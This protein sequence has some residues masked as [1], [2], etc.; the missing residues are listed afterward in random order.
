MIWLIVDDMN[1]FIELINFNIKN[2]FI[3]FKDVIVIIVFIRCCLL[4]VI[5]IINA[6]VLIWHVYIFFSI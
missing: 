3:C 6:F 2:L 4:E 5:G 1:L